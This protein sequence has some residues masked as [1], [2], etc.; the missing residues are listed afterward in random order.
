M[1]IGGVLAPDQNEKK[2]IYT[3]N[4]KNA[5]DIVDTMAEMADRI[6][7]RTRLMKSDIKQ[8]DGKTVE[9]SSAIPLLNI[10][11]LVQGTKAKI[12]G[13]NHGNEVQIPVTRN[14]ALHYP[15]YSNLVGANIP[16]FCRTMLHA[17]VWIILKRPWKNFISHI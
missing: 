10:A 1:G 16:G 4:A 2:G 6:S 12:T 3:F 17:I 13:A 15:G 9:I 11:V 7:G 14:V 5:G 8:V